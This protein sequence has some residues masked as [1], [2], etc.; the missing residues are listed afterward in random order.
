MV[1]LRPGETS[2]ENKAKGYRS[3]VSSKIQE[4]ASV[5]LF[6][7][8]DDVAVRNNVIGHVADVL[9]RI[10]RGFGEPGPVTFDDI[11]VLSI[12]IELMKL[13]RKR[14]EFKPIFSYLSTS[15]SPARAT[16]VASRIVEYELG[17]L[18]QTNFKKDIPDE[19]RKILLFE[20]IG[21]SQAEIIL[22]GHKFLPRDS[23]STRRLD[24][25]HKIDK[26]SLAMLTWSA[27]IE[28]SLNA[29]ARAQ[30]AYQF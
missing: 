19:V 12:A 10:E 25:I 18:A 8:L 3:T 29:G 9:Y 28:H 6:E 26:V 22:N 14:K 7:K 15:I 27:Q 30:F 11:V 1:T 23:Q 17:L 16:E 24:G 2:A 4:S 21:G 5:G 20:L 13:D